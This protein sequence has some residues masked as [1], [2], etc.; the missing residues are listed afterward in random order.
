MTDVLPA[1]PNSVALLASLEQ[2]GAVINNGLMLPPGLSFDQYESLG[3]MLR[4]LHEASQW[5]IGDWLA[6]GEME[7]EH[8]KYVQAAATTGLAPQTCMN[9][10]SIAKRIP[11]TRRR[12]RVKFSIHAEVA[13]LPPAEQ[14]RIL[15][16]AEQRELTKSEVRELARESRGEVPVERPCCS[17]CGRPL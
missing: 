13:S 15:K 11:P 7:Y 2:A 17:Q 4:H 3:V 5:L 12:P 9:Y 14:K 1:V 8:D 10:M 6:Y 16:E